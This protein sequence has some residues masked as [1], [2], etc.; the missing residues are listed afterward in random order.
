MVLN[1][2]A[3][4]NLV[5]VSIIIGAIYAGLSVL[6][7]AFAAHALK[8]IITPDQ[9]TIFKT[10]V[11]YQ[12]YHGLAFLWLGLYAMHPKT[13]SESNQKT[14]NKIGWFWAIGVLLFSGSLYVYVLTGAKFLVKITP[15]GG[16]S[17]II[18]WGMLIV[19]LIRN[20]RIDSP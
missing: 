1:P 8:H 7:G 5:S 14:I 6:L 2:K 13:N 9:L 10:G 19:S 11:S 4:N 17:M 20:S 15:I 18:G 12:M 16:V 3:K